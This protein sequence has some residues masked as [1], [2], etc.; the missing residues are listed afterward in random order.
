MKPY[1][2]QL[3]VRNPSAC[4]MTLIVETVTEDVINSFKTLQLLLR[5]KRWV[6]I[7]NGSLIYFHQRKTWSVWK[8]ST[9]RT[10]CC[11]L[12]IFFLLQ[13]LTF[14]F[15]LW[16]TVLSKRMLWRKKLVI[17]D[18]SGEVY[19]AGVMLSVV[20]L[21]KAKHSSEGVIN[22]RLTI[23]LNLRPHGHKESNIP[24]YY[25]TLSS[26]KSKRGG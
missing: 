1:N 23:D 10:K 7:N 17:H 21:L 18:I 24:L 16:G 8:K 19:V 2:N 15:N 25:L 4:L 20:L 6:L 11:A 13:T 26:T 12:L 3:E 5:M 9:V 14:Y 22:W